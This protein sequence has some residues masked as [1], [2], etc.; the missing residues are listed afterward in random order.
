[1][2]EFDDIEDMGIEEERIEKTNLK[3]EVLSTIRFF[4]PHF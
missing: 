3:K 4:I 2:E 1:M